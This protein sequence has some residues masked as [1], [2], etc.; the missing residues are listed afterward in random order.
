MFPQQAAAYEGVKHVIVL[1]SN[2]TEH[3][4]QH[5]PTA[6]SADTLRH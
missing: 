1:V 2:V 6:D 3:F 4:I 5:V